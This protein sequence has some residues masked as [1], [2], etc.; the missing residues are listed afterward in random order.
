MAVVYLITC[1]KTK[2]ERPGQS[3]ARDLYISPL[4]RKMRAL[5]E[6]EADRWYILSD[7]Y[8]LL[9]P[10]DAVEWYEVDLKKL[11]RAARACWAGKVLSALWQV[12]EQDDRIVM[13]AGSVYVRL[14]RAELERRGFAVDEPLHGLRIGERMARLN[15]LL[16]E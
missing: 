1:V 7:H 9:A 4:F 2:D 14:L 10:D 11:G 12:L 3:R 8:G 13:L 16:S 5:A 6:R 15:D